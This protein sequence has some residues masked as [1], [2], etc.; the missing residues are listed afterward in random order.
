MSSNVEIIEVSSLKKNKPTVVTGFTGPGFIANTALMYIV[1]NKGFKLRAQLRSHLIPPIILIINSKL[2]PSFRIYG[3]ETDRLLFVICDSLLAVENAW[4]IGLKLMEWLL[5]KG[6]K[7]IVSIEGMPFSVLAEEKPILG[8]STTGRELTQYGTQPT[9]EGGV[10]G[11][12]A[13]I[14]DESM[15]HG[16]PWISLFVPTPI[17][18]AIDYEG[19]AAIIEVLNKM[20]KLGVDVTPLR[21]TADARRQMI[22]KGRG[23][24][25]RGFLDSLRRKR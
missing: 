2:T 8:F 13:V 20:F 12:N 25:K 23:G 11:L 19:A 18:S 24:A 1:R 9:R 5:E 21:K 15:K 17:V 4:P 16:I 22:E 14:L 6:V 10:S 7:E 3:D